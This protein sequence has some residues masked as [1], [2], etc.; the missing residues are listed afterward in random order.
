MTRLP[1]FIIAALACVAIPLEAQD[2]TPIAPLPLGDHLLNIPTAYVLSKGQGEVRFT[3]RFSQPI[4]E[5]DFNSL[6]GLDSSADIGLALAYAPWRDLEL[7]VYRTNLQDSWEIGGKYELV[8][9]APRIPLSISL[10]GGA[11]VRTAEGLDDRV[12][13]FVQAVL[14]RQVSGRL[15]LFAVPSA[16]GDAGVFDYAFNLPLGAAYMLDPNLSLVVELVPGNR[17]NPD[18]FETDFG[19]AIGLKRAIG[20]HFF[21]IVLAD[22]RATQVSQYTT[23]SILMAPTVEGLSG[24][25]AGDVHIGFNIERRWGGR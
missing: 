6:W 4:N 2:Y 14:S 15:E 13:P 1:V 17:D 19:W 3:H 21:E 24:W 10:R 9:Q 25:R 20:G 8:R 22:T 12:T 11:D 16:V 5:G 18:G 7:F 23:G